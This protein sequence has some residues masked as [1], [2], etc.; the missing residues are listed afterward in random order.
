MKAQHVTIL[1][2]ISR[3]RVTYLWKLL[4]FWH[5]TVRVH[6]ALK[7]HSRVFRNDMLYTVILTRIQISVQFLWGTGRD[8]SVGIATCYGL[9]V[10]GDRNPVGP[11]FSAPVQTGPGAHPASSTMGT[12]PFPGVKLTRRGADHPPPSKRRGHERV[13]LYLY[14]PSGPQWPVIG[15]TSISSCGA[16]TTCIFWFL[17][18]ISLYHY[19]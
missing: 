5:C 13:R 6:R 10:S 4:Q 17:L 16:Q 12:V 7:R 8:S 14:S 1:W 15:R 11:R 2:P 18:K 3:T 19:Y 9:H